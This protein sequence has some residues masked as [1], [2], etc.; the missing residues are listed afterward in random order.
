M[1]LVIVIRSEIIIVKTLAQIF[2]EYE[3]NSFLAIISFALQ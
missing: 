2:Q 3:N 1:S